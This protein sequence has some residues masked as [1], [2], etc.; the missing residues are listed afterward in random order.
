MGL[1]IRKKQGDLFYGYQ[2]QTYP[3]RLGYWLV[4]AP[5]PLKSEGPWNTT[6]GY[7]ELLKVLG[8]VKGEKVGGV[9][10]GRDIQDRITQWLTVLCNSPP[11]SACNC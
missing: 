5:T 10:D 8:R 4:T 1:I 6:D 11:K 9:E 2:V 7:S 3:R